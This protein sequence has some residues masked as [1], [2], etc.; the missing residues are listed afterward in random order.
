MSCLIYSCK[1]T[2]DKLSMLRV[3]NVSSS[4][5]L[6]GVY[7]YE[8][9]LGIVALYYFYE[10]GVV[11][12][13]GSVHRDQLEDRL[14]R[15]ETADTD[16]YKNIKFLWGRYAISQ[17]AIRFERWYPS[18]KPYRAFMKEGEII[19][20]ST[21]VIT[22]SHRPNGKI[23]RSLQETYS[24]REMSKKPDHTNRWVSD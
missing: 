5:R 4:L 11:L 19:N 22:K 24:F 9:S 16:K 15:L 20:D 12:S 18:E 17:S 8:D 7:L 3:D 23:R 2:D 13:R 21:F 6:D 1:F 14:T 10:N